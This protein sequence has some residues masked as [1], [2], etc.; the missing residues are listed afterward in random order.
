MVKKSLKFL[1]FSETLPFTLVK[2][3]RTSGKSFSNV[4]YFS[5]I[6]P[7]KYTRVKD[8]KRINSVIVTSRIV[9]SIVEWNRQ[10]TE[11]LIL[12]LATVSKSH[13]VL[14]KDDQE[15]IFSLQLL[16]GTYFFIFAIYYLFITCQ[17]EATLMFLVINFPGW[18]HSWSTLD[19]KGCNSVCLGI[20]FLEI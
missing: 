2:N 14:R 5:S 12:H 15:D 18:H 3:K 10:K 16:R 6:L 8:R 19:S 11:K 7:N 20:P 9:S 4:L 13:H 17:R 1:A